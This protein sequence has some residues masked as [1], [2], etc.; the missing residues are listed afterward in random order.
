MSTEE[1]EEGAYFLLALGRRLG[2]DE[3]ASLERGCGV[4]ANAT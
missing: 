3:P 2:R 4:V 1:P